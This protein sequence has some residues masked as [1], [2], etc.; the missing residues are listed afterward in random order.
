MP[1]TDALSHPL[2]GTPICL[3]TEIRDGSGRVFEV[4][5][6]DAPLR[7]VVLRSG[8]RFIAWRNHC[9]HFGQPLALKDEWLILQAHQS[10][11]CNVHYARF[12]WETGVCF[13]GDCEGEQLDRIPVEIRDGALVIGTR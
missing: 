3:L 9:P 12:N 5:P 11:S 6:E 13:S 10:V 2:A 7:I 8:D 1:E 4:G